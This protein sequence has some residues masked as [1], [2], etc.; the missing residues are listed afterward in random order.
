VSRNDRC[1]PISPARRAFIAGVLAALA[2]PRASAHSAKPAPIAGFELPEPMQ[3]ADFRLSD[4]R[5]RAFTKQ[6]LRDRWTMLLFGFAQC[7]DVC[8]TALAQMAETRRAVGALD[9]RSAIGGVFVTI[10]PK[11]DSL[12]QLAS[13]VAR[14]DPAFI[15]VTGDVK[16]IRALA[17]QFRVRYEPAAGKPYL[18]DHTASVSLIGADARLYAIFSLPLAPARVAGDIVRLQGRSGSSAR[19]KEKP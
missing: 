2:A 4:H 6:S 3:L 12:A 15:G 11:R 9:P 5:G 17:E 7:P 16:S 14:F 18:F 19:A 1:S 10:D 8:P 13:Y